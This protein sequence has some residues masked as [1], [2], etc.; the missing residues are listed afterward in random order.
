[1]GEFISMMT[2][3]FNVPK[4]SCRE[5]YLVKHAN[6]SCSLRWDTQA[7]LPEAAPQN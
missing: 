1:M 2:D 3:G 6:L 7:Q 4:W 5:R